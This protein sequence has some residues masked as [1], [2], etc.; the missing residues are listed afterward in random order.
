MRGSLHLIGQ[1]PNPHRAGRG[2]ARVR[3]SERVMDSICIE[4]GDIS[5]AYQG[6]KIN[7]CGKCAKNKIDNYFRGRE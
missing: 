4:C 6:Y 2:R 7:I 1:T 5:T 3:E